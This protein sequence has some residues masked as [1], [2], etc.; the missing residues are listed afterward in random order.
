MKSKFLT[1]LALLLLFGPG[2]LMAQGLFE[3]FGFPRTVTATGHTE[4][5]GSVMVSLRQGTT[6]AGTL[7][8]DVSHFKSPMP[9]QPI[10]A[11]FR[12]ASVSAQ[13]QSMPRT[14][15][16]AYPFLLAGPLVQFVS[17]AFADQ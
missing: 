12:L 13:S 15:S 8:I 6:V 17:M 10:S 4:V 3:G 7:V 5:L 14:V 9:I 16:F 2:R 1:L 11:S